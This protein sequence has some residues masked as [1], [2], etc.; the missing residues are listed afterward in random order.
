MSKKP[1]RD[2][3]FR[4]VALAQD[5][6]VVEDRR[7]KA[8]QVRFAHGL[9]SILLDTHTVSTGKS[10]TTYTRA[11]CQARLNMPFRFA[12]FRENAF[13]RIG[14]M[15]G[16]QDLHAGNP[17][18]DRQFIVK[19]DNESMI[20]SLL[21]DPAV[22]RPLLALDSGRFDLVKQRGRLGERTEPLVE[23]RFQVAVVVKDA[24]RLAL[25]LDL[26]RGALDQLARNGVIG[27]PTAAPPR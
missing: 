27:A 9:F 23:L 20:R 10:S 24:A 25:V 6:E 16:M 7:G 11:R 19:S 1:T 21:I 26:M 13:T 15:L 2:D 8:K 22:Y 17:D 12:L 3:A 5:G 14:K 4:A 18:I